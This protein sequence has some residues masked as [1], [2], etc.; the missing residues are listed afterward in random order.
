MWTTYTFGTKS[1]SSHAA[2][3]A[4]SARVSC[5]QIFRQ[6]SAWD[7]GRRWMQVPERTLPPYVPSVSIWRR[8]MTSKDQEQEQVR[9]LCQRISIEEDPQIFDQLVMELNDL[10][11]VK[12]RRIRAERKTKPV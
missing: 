2:G 6:L 3:G 5:I 10:L 8:E 9:Y 4:L 11:E 7:A 1:S 12:H